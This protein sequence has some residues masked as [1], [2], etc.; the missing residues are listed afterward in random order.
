MI[1]LNK[2]GI[3]KF[4]ALK[5]TVFQNAVAHFVSDIVYICTANSGSEMT[6]DL[7][8]TW[9]LSVEIFWLY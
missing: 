3:F 7:E 9:N 5:T 1:C 4:T 8:I 6:N 2:S